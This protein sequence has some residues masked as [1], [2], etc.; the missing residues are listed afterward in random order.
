MKEKIL[1]KKKPEKKLLAPLKKRGGRGMDGKITVRG[2]GG[3]AKRRYRKVDFKRNKFK[4]KGKVLA[5]EYDPNRTAYLAL[6]E[7][8]DGQKSYILAPEGLKIGDEIISD[9]KAEIKIGNRMRLK[10]IPLGTNVYNI[11]ILPNQGGKLVRSAGTSAL[12]LAHEGKYSQVKMP[13]GEIRRIFS[14]CFAT[15]GKVSH[16]SWREERFKK[17]GERRRRGKRPKVRGSAM[18]PR[19]HPHG[20]GEGKAPIGLKHPKTPWGKPALGVKTRRKGHLF[21]K[22]I[23]K[24]RK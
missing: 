21:D 8:E 20:G 14:D 3:G 18:T 11:E 16:S 23:I 13:S 10:N 24:R 19:D 9:E 22:M 12:V 17:A 1:T 2:K 15:I 7:Y 6:I 4:V 5:F